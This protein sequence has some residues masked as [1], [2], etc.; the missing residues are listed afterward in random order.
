MNHKKECFLRELKRISMIDDDDNDVNGIHVNVK[1]LWKYAGGNTGSHLNFYNGLI[2]KPP[3]PEHQDKCLCGTDILRQR[4]IQHKI[5][6]KLIVVGSECITDFI[7]KMRKTCQYR[8]NGVVCGKEHKTLKYMICKECEP[9][10]KAEFEANRFKPKD[11][12]DDY[13][14]EL[15][16]IIGESEEQARKIKEKSLEKNRY[17]KEIER[18][19]HSKTPEIKYKIKELEIRIRI[20]SGDKT[21]GL[22]EKAEHNQIKYEIHTRIPFGKHKY[23][24]YG[25]VIKY[26]KPYAKWACSID[27]KMNKLYNYIYEEEELTSESSEIVESPKPKIKVI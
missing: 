10:A 11:D 23:Q 25:W 21:E 14:K 20:L 8:I 9:L 16:N 2:P 1:D 13:Q 3:M 19:R 5:T 22:L 17:K 18:H 27:P 6:G 26:D 12:M 24:K 7:S 15:Y 4:F